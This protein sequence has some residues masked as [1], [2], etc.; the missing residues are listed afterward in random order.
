[1]HNESRSKGNRSLQFECGNDNIA[2]DNIAIHKIR[3]HI[4]IRSFE[5]HQ[6]Y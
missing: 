3:T 1:M 4:V 2:I 6:S 5:D